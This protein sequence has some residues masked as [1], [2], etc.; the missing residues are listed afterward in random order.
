MRTGSG[1]AFAAR[2][3]IARHVVARQ[4]VVRVVRVVRVV[5]AG[6]AVAALAAVTTGCGSREGRATDLSTAAVARIN[7][8]ACDEPP[9]GVGAQ[10]WRALCAAVR[11]M[12]ADGA[13]VKHTS[14]TAQ[15]SGEIGYSY[16][17][18]ATVP[19]RDRRDH[20]LR[21]YYQGTG[22]SGAEP[23]LSYATLD[24]HVLLDRP[25]SG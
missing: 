25:G 11:S 1:T 10:P 14:T 6:L 13:S 15:Q 8:G 17:S 22:L 3:V 23:Q 21:L 5:A 7:R 19:G 12:L 2:H 16:T 24:R 4:V 20:T 18:E 9:D